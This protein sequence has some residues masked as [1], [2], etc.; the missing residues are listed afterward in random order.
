MGKTRGRRFEKEGN[1]RWESKGSNYESSDEL[2][3]ASGVYDQEPSFH[4][5][6]GFVWLGGGSITRATGTDSPWATWDSESIAAQHSTAHGS[7]ARDRCYAVWAVG[8][9]RK[10]YRFRHLEMVERCRH[11]YGERQT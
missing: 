7:T 5:A 10:T 6:F 2:A 4:G 3:T 8:R 11:G 9:P 1:V